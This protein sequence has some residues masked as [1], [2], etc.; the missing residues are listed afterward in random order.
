ML[1]RLT[2]EFLFINSNYDPYVLP[3]KHTLTFFSVLFF[4]F[5]AAIDQS[6]DWRAVVS[7]W[8]VKFPRVRSVGPWKEGGALEGS[9]HPSLKSG[10]PHLTHLP[11]LSPHPG[12]WVPLESNVPIIPNLAIW[13]FSIP[14]IYLFI[15]SLS[16]A[17]LCNPH[18]L[19]HA[20]L[21][22]SSPSPRV[23]SNSCP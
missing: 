6:C 4:F 17:Q 3:S 23:C 22:C 19:Q 11:H 12:P 15:Q 16:R 10:C 18:G 20:R 1:P 8:N 13:G 9:L 5:F 21:P 7:Q 2:L 14:I